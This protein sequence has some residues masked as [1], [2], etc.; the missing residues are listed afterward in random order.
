MAGTQGQNQR[1]KHRQTQE[2][3]GCFH[4][5]ERSTIRDTA[6]LVEWHC[7]HAT[8]STQGQTQRTKLT[9]TD[10]GKCDEEFTTWQRRV[11][12]VR[13]TAMLV[14]WHCGHAT[15]ITQGQTQ[16]TKLNTDS[17][18]KVWGGNLPRDRKGVRDIGMRLWITHFYNKLLK[19][20]CWGKTP[21]T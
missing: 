3:W 1:A 12:A 2:M 17:R 14:E 11:H 20:N 8:F 15:V 7:G 6:M 13:D 19:Q 18:R 10:V 9:Q 5:T 16:R 21:E 4:A